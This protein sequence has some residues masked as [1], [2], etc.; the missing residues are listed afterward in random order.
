MDN[1]FRQPVL[2]SKT[3]RLFLKIVAA[4]LTLVAACGIKIP[5]E[6]RGFAYGFIQEIYKMHTL[7]GVRHLSAINGKHFV[8]KYDPVNE[9]TAPLVLES[10]ERAYNQLAKK[11]SYFNRPIPVI[12]YS[13]RQALNVRFGWPASESAM[14][15]YWEGVIHVLAPE[16]WIPEG[17]KIDDYFMAN[18]PMAHEIT[19]LFVDNITRGNVPRWFTEG[20]AQYEENKLTGFKFR[21][22]ADLLSRH[23]DFEE[24]DRNFDR[25]TD[26]QVAYSQSFLAV[27]YLVDRYGENSVRQI[28]DTLAAGKNFDAGL[29]EITG[30]HLKEFTSNW[31][32]WLVQKE[33]GRI[34][35]FDG[36]VYGEVYNDE[37]N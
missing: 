27:A 17:E 13:S 6:A 21:E 18:G 29:K 3:Q 23:Y 12:M 5:A 35:G 8:V 28:L 36:E 10:A 9:S 19:H 33:Q 22:P 26:Q 20:L 11:Y 34:I 7:Y 32:D 37:R 15:A 24:M 14:G 16:V 31:E 2:S 4:V 1:L 25:L 30:V